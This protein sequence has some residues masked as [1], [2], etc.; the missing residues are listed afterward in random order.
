MIKHSGKSIKEMIRDLQAME[1]NLPTKVGTVATNFFLD[2]FRLQGFQG[3]LG[4]QKWPARK[5]KGRGSKGR[6]LLVKS[7]ALRRSIVKIPGLGRVT[8]KAGSPA[9][10]YADAHNFGVNEIINVK[11]HQRGIKRTV[12]TQ[13]SNVTTRRV[14]SRKVKVSSGSAEV[15]A[16]SRMMRLPQRKFIGV[17]KKL[18]MKIQ[19][20]IDQEL[21]KAFTR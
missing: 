12:R 10:K 8:V 2:N 6:A 21:R 11:S 3:D 9:E 14:Q 15:K 19:Q 20:L 1:R 18:D 7:G 13:F 17:S 4:L 5:D 16:H